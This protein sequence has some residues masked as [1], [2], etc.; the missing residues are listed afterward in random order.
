[1]CFVPLQSP[2]D[3]V[4]YKTERRRRNALGIRETAIDHGGGGADGGVAGGDVKAK[5]AG[6]GG[7]GKRRKQKGGKRR[8]LIGDS[9]DEDDDGDEYD[10][11]GFPISDKRRKK[12]PP[13]AKKTKEQRAA[14]AAAAKEASRRARSDWIWSGWSLCEAYATKRG[15]RNKNGVLDVYR[16]GNELLRDALNGRIV[17]S[18]APP[19]LS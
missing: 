11:D 9:D 8:G 10:I 13:A 19:K 12:K 7:G 16:A 15:Y 17:L 5:G 18:F 3:T 2:S 1:L 14:D 4:N 6:G